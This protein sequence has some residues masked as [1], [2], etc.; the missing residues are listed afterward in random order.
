MTTGIVKQ[1]L[2]VSQVAWDQQEK[3]QVRQGDEEN[4]TTYLEEASQEN[5]SPAVSTSSTSGCRN[6]DVTRRDSVTSAETPAAAQDPLTVLKNCLKLAGIDPEQL[7]LTVEEGTCTY[8]GGS[9]VNRHIVAEIGGQSQYYD[10]NLMMR[11][12]WVTVGEIQS[13]RGTPVMWIP[14]SLPGA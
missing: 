3:A 2:T 5:S 14:A 4:F 1:A 7:N 11:N 9:W 12:P 6:P 8:P 10:I 13:A